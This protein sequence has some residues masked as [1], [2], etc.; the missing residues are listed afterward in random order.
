MARWDERGGTGYGADQNRDRWRDDD[1][2]RS[3]WRSQGQGTSERDDERGFF[4]R[5]ATKSA[6]GLATMTSAAQAAIMGAEITVA[7]PPGIA[8]ITAV[9]EIRAADGLVVPLGI[10]TAAMAVAG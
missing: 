1:R 4:E 7:G 5:A 10:A 9:P 8:T 6:R 3:T 2:E